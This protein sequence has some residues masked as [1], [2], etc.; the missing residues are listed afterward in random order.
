MDDCFSPCTS[1]HKHEKNRTKT[2][3]VSPDYIKI[4]FGPESEKL[5]LT[6]EINLSA[7]KYSASKSFSTSEFYAKYAATM[8]Q[9]IQQFQGTGYNPIQFPSIDI[10]TW[11]ASAYV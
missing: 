10:T 4:D 11:L 2:L 8:F 9:N 1:Q 5:H 6:S 3:T 7:D